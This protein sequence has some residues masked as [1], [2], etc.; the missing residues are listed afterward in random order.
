MRLESE[1]SAGRSGVERDARSVRARSISPA[2]SACS[3][4]DGAG[5]DV[6]VGDGSRAGAAVSGRGE[7]VGVRAP[8]IDHAVPGLVDAEAQVVVGHELGLA[9]G[10]GPASLQPGAGATAVDDDVQRVLELLFGPVA[11]AGFLVS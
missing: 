5:G 10:S 7:G 8:D 1:Y 2:I 6:V 3:G 4:C 11:A 9:H